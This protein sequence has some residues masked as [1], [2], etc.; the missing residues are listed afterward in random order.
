M[1]EKLK[2]KIKLHS[3]G[4]TISNKSHFQK[5]EHYSNDV[6]L[7]NE[8]IEKWTLPF[9]L[10]VINEPNVFSQRLKPIK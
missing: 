9:Y 2:K 7:E 5:I 1:D 8:F 3:A 10:F 6:K 4:A